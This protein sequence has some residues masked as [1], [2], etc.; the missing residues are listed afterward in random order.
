MSGAEAGTFTASLDIASDDPDQ[1]TTRIP[2]RGT[3]VQAA[4]FDIGGGGGG[5]CFIDGLHLDRSAGDPQPP[6]GGGAQRSIRR[7][8]RASHPRHSVACY[9][10]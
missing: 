2:L 4:P 9:N 8:W 6:L 7:N 3:V 10:L 1:P 5:G